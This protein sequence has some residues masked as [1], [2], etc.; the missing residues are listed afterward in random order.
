MR[1]EHVHGRDVWVK[2]QNN[3]LHLKVEYIKRSVHSCVALLDTEILFNICHLA[4]TITQ[5]DS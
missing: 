4:D 2:V 1:K 3:Y 5:S